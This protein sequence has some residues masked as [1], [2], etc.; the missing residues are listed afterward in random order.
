L[1]SKLV[2]VLVAPAV[3]GLWILG[4]YNRLVRMRNAIASVFSAFAQ[5]VQERAELVTALLTLSREL[6]PADSPQIED[7][8]RAER[9]ATS[10]LDAAK[11]RPVGHDQITRFGGSDQ[12]LGLALAELCAALREHVGYADTQSDPERLHPAV[13]QLG[14]LDDAL[15]QTDFARMT[16]NMAAND[17]NDAVR[18]FPTALVAALFRFGPAA[19]L[20][21][22]PRGVTDK[23]R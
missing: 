20:P 12:A 1:T 18:M 10:A 19:L 13:S 16:Y 5:Q 9:E 22:V 21:T 8:V 11:A 6:L 23:R 14:R 4:A 7:M 3:L 15:T 17:Y 2:L